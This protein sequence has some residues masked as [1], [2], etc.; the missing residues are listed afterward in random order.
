VAGIA[1]VL[2]A[3]RY[4]GCTGSYYAGGKMY[5]VFSLTGLEDA[6]TGDYKASSGRLVKNRAIEGCLNVVFLPACMI[7]LLTAIAFIAIAIAYVVLKKP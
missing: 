7:L 1:A 3:Y 2:E 5:D 6:Y 4:T